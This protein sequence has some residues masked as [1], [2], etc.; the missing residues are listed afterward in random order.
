MT[1]TINNN[2]TNKDNAAN[3]AATAANVNAAVAPAVQDRAQP[4]SQPG[5]EAVPTAAPMS[6]EQFQEFMRFQQSQMISAQTIAAIVQQEVQKAMGNLNMKVAEVASEQASIKAEMKSFEQYEAEVELE[7]ERKQTLIAEHF[8]THEPA[9]AAHF[10]E[11][12]DREVAFEQYNLERVQ[13][14]EDYSKMLAARL[15]SLEKA[16]KTGGMANNNGSSMEDKIQRF[17]PQL[18]TSLVDDFAPVYYKHP[19]KVEEY[20][21]QGLDDHQALLKLM[22]IQQYF[23]GN[24]LSKSVWFVAAQ[25]Y[26][27]GALATRYDAILLS[28]PSWKQLAISILESQ[29]WENINMELT[30]Q[31]Q[32]LEPVE[33]ETASSFINRYREAVDKTINYRNKFVNDKIVLLSKLQRCF[34]DTLVQIDFAAFKNPDEF[35]AKLSMALSNR[36]F[37]NTVSLSTVDFPEDET[38]QIELVDDETGQVAVAYVQKGKFQQQ[39]RRGNGRFDRTPSANNYST[40]R[41]YSSNYNTRQDGKNKFQN[42]NNNSYHKKQYHTR[43]DSYGK[44]RYQN[45][46]VY[47]METDEQQGDKI[48]SFPIIG[49]VVDNIDPVNVE[50]ETSDAED[51]RNDAVEARPRYYQY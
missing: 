46:S 18:D 8:N 4:V 35:Y 12:E 50:D 16:T 45:K 23:R 34:S 14:I 3:N 33:G 6:Q 21:I 47:L 11:V 7:N 31:A 48:D 25:I 29:N 9:E 17:L 42:N 20:V 19:A 39:Y 28:N 24:H 41:N 40:Y 43:W 5:S 2:S 1:E 10:K 51:A 27:N 30:V 15:E 49:Q 44:G 26:M 13:N 36:K 37:T 38:D 32:K 22:K